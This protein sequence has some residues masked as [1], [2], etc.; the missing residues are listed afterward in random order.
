MFQRFS[1]ILQEYYTKEDEFILNLSSATP[2]IKSALFVINRLNGINVKA[3][4][5]SSPEHASNKNIGH[6]NDENIDELIK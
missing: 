4:K 6:D 2:Q 3:V 5:V 1:D